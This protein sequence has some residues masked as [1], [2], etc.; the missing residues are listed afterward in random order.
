MRIC[1]RFSFYFTI[2]IV[3]LTTHVYAGSDTRIAAIT[4][5]SADVTL[6]FIQPGRIANVHVKEGESV[7]T[8]Q[9][10]VQ[11]DD[12]V[13]QARLAQI[14]ADSKNMTNIEAGKASLAQKRVDL[15]KLEIAAS[16]NAATE[17]EVEH[18]KLD[19]KIAELSLE[20]A[21]FEHEQAVRKYDEAKLQINNMNLK[22]P[23]SGSIEKVEVE[24][25]ES[26]N[27]LEGVV[28]VVQIDPL[29]IEVP[30]PLTLASALTHRD[31]AEVHFPGPDK[32]SINGT[33]VFIA[34]VAD[35]GSGTLRVRVGVPN[36]A[37]RPAGGHVTVVFPTLQEK[38]ESIRK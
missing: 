15:R 1:K 35:A 28:R 26:V 18:A 27:A 2:C 32:R 33:I 19:V 17:L 10:L 7:K 21:I 13:D 16:R 38:K 12:T 23:I 9:V 36:K 20:V 37:K 11:Q 24:T 25:G 14:E 3:M 34:A 4:N 29:W 31:T 30:A 8:G 22:S 6:S 5:P